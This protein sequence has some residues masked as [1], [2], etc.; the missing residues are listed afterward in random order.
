MPGIRN[1]N[2]KCSERA[3]SPL[4]DNEDPIMNKIE[5]SSEEMTSRNLLEIR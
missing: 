3:D 5:V 1:A 2:A 4:T